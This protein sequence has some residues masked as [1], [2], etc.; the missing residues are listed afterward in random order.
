MV[1]QAIRALIL[2]QTCV[3][4]NPQSAQNPRHQR[5]HDSATSARNQAHFWQPERASNALVF[6]ASGCAHSFRLVNHL[7]G[8]FLDL[9]GHLN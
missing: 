1:R 4:D 8:F 9:F 7:D 5:L 3:G 6:M 2:Q